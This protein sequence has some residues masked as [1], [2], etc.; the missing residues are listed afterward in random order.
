MILRV[1]AEAG[2]E[3]VTLSE[4]G[5]SLEEVYLSVVEANG[6]DQQ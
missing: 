3:V 4:V 1:M 6:K 2:I 5:R